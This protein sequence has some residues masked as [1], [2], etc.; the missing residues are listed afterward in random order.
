MY[1]KKKADRNKFLKYIMQKSLKENWKG[2]K[3]DA[4]EMKVLENKEYL[5]P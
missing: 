5:R 4:V 3:T 1:F 2:K